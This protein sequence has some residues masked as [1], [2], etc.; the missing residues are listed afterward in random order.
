MSVLVCA[1]VR[2]FAP[3][4]ALGILGGAERADVVLHVNGCAR[5]Q[6]YVAQLTEAADAIP[7]LVPEAEPPPDFETRVLRR[8]VADRR[9][10]RRRWVASIAAVAAAVAIF[11][12]T[13]VRIIESGDS[14]SANVAAPAALVAKPVAVRMESTPA[15]VPAGWAYVSGR[16]GVAV[17]VSYGV[18]SGGYSVQVKS[19]DGRAETLGTMTID[20]NHGSWTGR[21]TQ[22]ITSGS[23][24]A[25]VDATG[26]AVCHG[27]VPAAQ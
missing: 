25:L 10:D 11:S 22:P 13:V 6:A 5:C 4:L 20:G 7:L 15:K 9:R 2:E 24:V 16:H 17:T 12:I 14:T 23:T 19:P 3:E 27:I 26:V 21:S 8:L 18:G 1:E